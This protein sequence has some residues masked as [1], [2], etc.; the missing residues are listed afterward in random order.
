MP[1]QNSDIDLLV[2]R[3]VI[4]ARKRHDD[5][6][7]VFAEMKFDDFVK[8]VQTLGKTV[9]ELH[10][11]GID[12]GHIAMAADYLAR[13]VNLTVLQDVKAEGSA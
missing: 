3:L 13:A 11:L 6:L 4:A 1:I 10:K 12:L 8:S 5:G 7:E 2:E 9:A